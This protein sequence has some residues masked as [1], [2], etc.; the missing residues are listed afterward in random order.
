MYDFYYTPYF[1]GVASV[2]DREDTHE[3]DLMKAAQIGWTFF[4]IAYIFKRIEE[5]E[6]RP[7]PIMVLFAKGMDAKNFH[8]EKLVPA[9]RATRS[10]RKRVDVDT[11]RKS[12]NRWDNKEFDGGFIKL[13]GSNSPGNVKSTSKV[14]LGVVEEPD[15]TTD[16]VAGQGDAIGLLEE[17]LKR[18]I[19]SLLIVGGTPAVKGL[20]KTE[21]RLEQTNKCVLPIYCHECNQAHVLDFD[22]VSWHED[23]EADHVVYGKALPET[24]VYVCPHC[25]TPWDDHQRQENIRNT[26][27]DAYN[28]GDELAGWIPTADFH[29][30]F[31]FIRLSELYVCMPGTGLADVV[32]DKLAADHE[33]SKGDQNALIKFT[34]QKLGLPYEFK[35]DYATAD[36]LRAK[37][38]DYPELVVPR[39]GLLLT[40]GIDVQHDRVAVVMRAWGRDEQSWGVYWGELYAENTT[41]DKSDAVWDA[42]DALVFSPVEHETGG[43]IYANAISID[44]SDGVTNDAVYHWVRTR[45]KRKRS[46]LVM[47][48]K[49]SSSQS[50]PEIFATPKVKSIDHINPEKQTKAD[51]HGVK[52]YQVGTNKAKDWLASHMK[53]EGFGSGRHHMYKDVRADYFDQVTGE[54][55]APHKSVRHRLVWQQ[56]SG[57]AVEAWDC[58]VY[59]LHAARARRIHLKKP[60]EWDAL[61]NKITQGDL[62]S[63]AV[64]AESVAKEKI[65]AVVESNPVKKKRKPKK[66]TRRKRGDGFVSQYRE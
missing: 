35:G 12:G 51:K 14:G 48:I 7:C 52:I 36:Q 1:L 8:D 50:D 10:I 64:A 56:K 3:I 28:N 6:V 32:R 65:E 39:G 19:K 60:K 2:F 21:A 44:S 9:V 46:I 40:V 22:N 66:S 29:G 49:G 58:E 55:K 57:R 33:A 26:C 59:A 15:D 43:R 42:L 23:D 18:Y 34:N 25:G 27:F 62:F 47:A 63:Q 61:E 38:L 17:R 45:S 53:M 41:A 4:L 16:N 30:K 20:S 37:A 5:A 13:V 31:G 11:S 54:V 24:A